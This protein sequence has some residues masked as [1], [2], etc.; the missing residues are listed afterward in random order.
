MSGKPEGDVT[1]MSS[2]V[3]SQGSGQWDLG[4]G[5]PSWGNFVHTF[6]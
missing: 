5:Y 1:E 3:W 6:N 4:R 2:G